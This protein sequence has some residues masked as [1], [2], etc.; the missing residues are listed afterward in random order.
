MRSEASLVRGV[1]RHRR[2]AGCGETAAVRREARGV[3]SDR[4]S[5][6]IA[7]VTLFGQ[8]VRCI[9]PGGRHNRRRVS[10]AV[11]HVAAWLQGARRSGALG[12]EA[13][14]AYAAAR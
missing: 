13:D 6:G 11:E 3:S 12:G 10:Q 5:P 1:R 14:E 9:G 8:R 2:A 7:A 4:C